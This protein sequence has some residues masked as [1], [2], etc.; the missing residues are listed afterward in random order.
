M[1]PSSQWKIDKTRFEA[2]ADFDKIAKKIGI[3]YLL[4]GAAARDLINDSIG[5]A[6][7]RMTQ[8]IDMAI[9]VPDWDKFNEL[10]SD[11]LG[12]GKFSKGKTPRHR[13]FHL[14][15]GLQLDLLPF[16]SIDGD[17]HVIRWPAPDHTSMSTLGFEEAYKSAIDAKISRNPDITIKISSRPGLAIMKLIAWNDNHA[18]RAKDAQDLLHMIRNYLDLANIQRLYEDHANIAGAEDF[19]FECAGARLMGRDIASLASPRVLTEIDDVLMRET[20][21]ECDFELV[22][23]MVG[24]PSE[25]EY[26]HEEILRLIKS[27]WDGVRD[28]KERHDGK[29]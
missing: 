19:D 16:G 5:I 21:D 24:S 22:L 12:S 18:G 6:G 3:P 23:D 26:R 25:R 13:H 15:T 14:S 8:D 29:F 9:R 2:I 7:Y 17:D 11:M 1:T 27:L 20:Q 4:V 28:V 10:S